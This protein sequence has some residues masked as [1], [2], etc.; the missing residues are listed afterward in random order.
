[1]IESSEVLMRV[2]RKVRDAEEAAAL[3]DAAEASGMARADWARRHGIDA[4]SLNAWRL[5]LGRRQPQFEPA[6]LR[7]VEVVR[8]HAANAAPLLVR[9]GP[10]SMEI[11][12]GTDE[13]LLRRVLG[14]MASC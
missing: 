3:L 14:A 2:A 9:C 1:V 7:L 5:N 10:F 8:T 13:E 4:R 6:A 12:E 11:G